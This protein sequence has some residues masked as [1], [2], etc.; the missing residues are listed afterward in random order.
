MMTREKVFYKDQLAGF[1]EKT[2]E[3]QF[4]FTY[5]EEYLTSSYPAISLTL[6]K[7]E[8]HFESSDLFAFFDAGFH[9]VWPVRR[10][11]TIYIWKTE[12]VI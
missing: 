7:I 8:K 6:P 9:R 4:I 5:E 10:R 1:I 11:G 3:D 2:A 12:D